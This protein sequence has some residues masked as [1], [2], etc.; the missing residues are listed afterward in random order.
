M[1]A[2]L[3]QRISRTH[4]RVCNTASG[5]RIPPCAVVHLLSGG[6][7]FGSGFASKECVFL[8]YTLLVQNAFADGIETAPVGANTQNPN[9]GV[10][11]IRASTGRRLLKDGSKEDWSKRWSSNRPS[12]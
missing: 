3:A 7:A 12:C 4:S 9:R 5:L 11:V 10:A 2:V 6:S 1:E 8:T